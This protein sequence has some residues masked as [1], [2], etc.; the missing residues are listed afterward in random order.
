MKAESINS[1]S[2]RLVVRQGIDGH[3]S[4]AVIDVG[5]GTGKCILSTTVSKNTGTEAM[6]CRGCCER[7]GWYVG[8]ASMHAKNV[9][10][11]DVLNGA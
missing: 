2:E 8:L 11:N 6:D 1:K 9:Q 10:D 7:I 3:A 5:I 4:G